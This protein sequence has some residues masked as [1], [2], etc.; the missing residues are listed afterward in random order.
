LANRSNI[1]KRRFQLLDTLLKWEGELSNGRIRDLLGLQIVQVSR[2]LSEYRDAH[3]GR[4]AWEPSRKRYLRQPSRDRY[5]GTVDDYLRLLDEEGNQSTWIERLDTSVSSVTPDVLIAMRQAI[6]A[7]HPI[8]ILYASMTHPAG[9]ERDIFPQHIVQAGRR[10]HIRAW[11]CTRQEYRDFVLGRI[12]R[13]GKPSVLAMPEVADDAWETEVDVR[14]VPHRKLSAAQAKV[15]QDELF[16]GTMARRF[17]TRGCLVPYVVQ[18]LR[19]SVSLDQVPPDYQVEVS[20][21]DEIG[22]YLFAK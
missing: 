15:I 22:K 3:P 8:R 13:I 2:L 6:E 19:A 4:M 1:Q 11:C 18:D 17:R 14:L 21:L 20:N 9:V 16:E 10:W 12:R 7:G 5:G